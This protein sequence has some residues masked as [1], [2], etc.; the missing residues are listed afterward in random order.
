MK[1][2]IVLLL[3]ATASARAAAQRTEMVSS[4]G[5]R[6]LEALADPGIARVVVDDG[7]GVYSISGEAPAVVTLDRNVTI[8]GARGSRTFLD[9]GY[10]RG[11]LV[12]CP[13]CV[14]TIANITLLNDRRGKGIL[15]FW[16]TNDL[17]SAPRGGARV[18][19]DGVHMLRLGCTT[20][21]DTGQII[22]V[23]KRSSRFPSD[24]AAQHFEI[25]NVSIRGET[26]PDSIVGLDYS[27]DA[28]L[29]TDENGTS[30]GYA[31]HLVNSARACKAVVTQA[32]LDASTPDACTNALVDAALAAQAAAAAR[33]RT[34]RAVAIAVPLAAAA[35]LAA[36]LAGVIVARRRRAA[37]LR[38]GGASKASAASGGA[39]LAELGGFSSIECGS[40]DL[41]PSA[42]LGLG[43]KD[44]GMSRDGGSESGSVV[45]KPFGLHRGW[46]VASSLTTPYLGA[47][48]DTKIVF[49]E[50]LGQGSFG[51]VYLGRWGGKDVAVKVIHHTTETAEL[52]RQEADVLLLF[53]HPNIVRCFHYTMFVRSRDGG[54]LSA[55]FTLRRS[56]SGHPGSLEFGGPGVG[57]ADGWDRDTCSTADSAADAEARQPVA[58]ASAPLATVGLPASRAPPAKAETWL[59]QEYC[60]AG[61]LA[62]V[63]AGWGAECDAVMLQRLLLLQDIA[64]GLQV[65]HDKKVVHGDLNTR[66]VLVASNP[67]AQWGL[68]A[69][70][71]DLGCTRVVMQH[72][73]HHTTN[74]MGTMSHMPPEV[75]R[76]GCFAP[77]VDIYSFGIMMWE[78]YTQQPA[79]RKLHYAQFY[80]AICIQNLRPLTTSSMPADYKLLMERCWMSDPADRPCATTLLQCLRHLPDAPGAA[81]ARP[82]GEEEQAAAG[83]V[84]AL[85]QQQPDRAPGGAQPDPGAP[86]P[87]PPPPAAALRGGGNLSTTVGSEGSFRFM[88]T[89]DGQGA[90]ADCGATPTLP[91]PAGALPGD[92]ARLGGGEPWQPA[93]G[94]CG[95]DWPL[96]AS[97]DGTGDGTGGSTAASSP[98]SWQRA[99]A[100]A[101]CSAAA[102]AGAGS[103]S[104]TPSPAG[105]LEPERRLPPNAVGDGPWF[106]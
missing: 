84:S 37:R 73:T 12:L 87:P 52:V 60:D 97:G 58:P 104:L 95:G 100:A 55:S 54:P 40:G 81:A 9:L 4:G 11:R 93:P 88:G 65:L 94:A 67:V 76:S 7:T 47:M 82:P 14:L 71:S 79:F 34:L 15:S 59:V 72:S 29:S 102:A 25:A 66:N 35:L 3:V 92:A 91:R 21:K 77:A 103:G 36:A 41:G 43:S 89:A 18:V 78:L 30:G 70:L 85:L 57:S 45:H 69:K 98:L 39:G 28:P 20:I 62:T 5:P 13:T 23:T 63:A 31:M 68:V 16:S 8:T 33:A 86:G 17:L 24:D 99:A 38:R 90:Q 49:G 61:T 22:S 10:G 53:N 101:P 105:S 50:L 56:R 44:A 106:V 48:T 46:H 83:A 2:L 64:R 27:I 42:P 51:R 19:Y 6:L 32:C 1:F 74:G 26:Y 80:E 75:L 96:D